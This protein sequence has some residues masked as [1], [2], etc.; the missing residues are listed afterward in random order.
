MGGEGQ[1]TN[2]AQ[3]VTQQGPLPGPLL[4]A[5]PLVAVQDKRHDV[6]H[7]CG[8]RDGQHKGG[9]C[10]AAQVE[11]AAL[12]R[13]KGALGEGAVPSQVP[14]SAGHANAGGPFLPWTQL[15]EEEFPFQARCVLLS[16]SPESDKPKTQLWSGSSVLLSQKQIV[17]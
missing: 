9:D 11:Q 1:K 13:E 15:V 4:W 10:G 7:L 6:T 16:A 12:G 8:S 5:R 2:P 17:L 14:K 3:T